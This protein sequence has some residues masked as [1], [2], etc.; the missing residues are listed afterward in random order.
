MPPTACITMCRNLKQRIAVIADGKNA[1]VN[2]ID[3]K[4]DLEAAS[5]VML[6]PVTG[7]GKSCAKLSTLIVP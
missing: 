3:H 7:E 5:R 2:K 6:A 1:D 4:D